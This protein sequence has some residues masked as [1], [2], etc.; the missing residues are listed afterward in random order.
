MPPNGMFIAKLNALD[1]TDRT[2]VM[3]A[4]KKPLE[5]FLKK[6]MNLVYQLLTKS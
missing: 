3:E 2:E 4:E 1:I 5:M 6:A